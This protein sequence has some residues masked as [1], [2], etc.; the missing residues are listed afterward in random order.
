MGHL[1]TYLSLSSRR[2]RN[3]IQ[4]A[5][6]ILGRHV[7]KGGFMQSVQAR[8]LFQRHRV[9]F[10]GSDLGLQGP[11][12]KMVGKSLFSGPSVLS[13][14]AIMDQIHPCCNSAEVNGPTPELNLT[15]C[16]Y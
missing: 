7:K 3:W 10:I 11:T 1:H 8:S 12:Q 5:V 2:T 9:G 6:G 13:D 14:L 16:Y 15:Q 4:Q